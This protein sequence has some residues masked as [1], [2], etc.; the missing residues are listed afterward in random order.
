MKKFTKVLL[1]LTLIAAL[2][3]PASLF[4][5]AAEATVPTAWGNTGFEDHHSGMGITYV[6][7]TSDADCWAK[8]MGAGTDNADS[9]NKYILIIDG[10][11]Y[12]CTK[13]SVYNGGTWG[14]LRID[15]TSGGFKAKFNKEYSVAW[16]VEAADGSWAYT[17]GDAVTVSTSN[18]TTLLTKEAITGKG[19]EA[20]QAMTSLNDKVDQDSVATNVSTYN[21][22]TETVKSVFDGDLTNKMGSGSN[23]VTITW[24]TTE[25][26]TVTDYVVVSGNDVKNNSGRNPKSWVLYGSNDGETW[27]VIDTVGV[28]GVSIAGFEAAVSTPYGFNVDKP[29]AYTN[30]KMELKSTSG[31]ELGEL[32]LYSNPATPDTPDT[33]DT[34][35]TP[36]TPDV[37]DTGD[38]VVIASLLSA[39]SLAGTAFVS[40]KRR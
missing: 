17:G 31:F 34:P 7:N 23:E 24:S 10:T 11:E 14:Y 40:K 3:V 13:T 16:K 27:T 1:V 32:V 39:I 18:C 22:T 26:I 15:A 8:I 36:D 4:S 2:V 28:E 20:I 35:G 37:P 29:G 33:P 30:Y 5:F 21:D 38:V 25:A 19:L 6:F 12:V 9:T